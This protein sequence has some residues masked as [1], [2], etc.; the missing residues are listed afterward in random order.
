MEPIYDAERYL[1]YLHA[2]SARQ[3]VP[4]SGTFELTARCNLDC[5]MCYIHRRA[6]DREAVAREKDT[7]FWLALAESARDAGML[8]LLL[9]GG[10]PMLRPDFAILLRTLTDMGLLVSINTNGTLLTPELLTVMRECPPQRVNVTLYGA[11]E[12]T[13]RAL[14]G[15]G[16]VYPRVLRTIE[17]MRDAGVQVKINYSVTP[18]NR[19]DLGAAYGL[20]R[21]WKLPMQA[22][23]YMFPPIRAR[24]NGEYEASRL[25]PEEAAA[26]RLRFDRIRYSPKVYAERRERMLSGDPYPEDGDCPD[27]PQERIRC[28]AGSSCFWVTWDGCMRPCG[29]MTT[30]SVRLT[31]GRFETF[32]GAW[33]TLRREREKIL[34]PAKCSAC[35][36]RFACGVCPAACLAETGRY[37]AVP[38]YLCRMTGEYLKL[39]HEDRE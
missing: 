32:D 11:S 1:Q 10:E 22:V 31:D 34:V 33:Q 4:L 27:Q 17:L 21:E 2:L 16:E 39:L 3:G 24:E 14:C 23:P 13:Y 9:T 8:S 25:S 15:S 6:Q 5:R 26:E 12:E 30:P 38:E 37:E 18:Y 29:M 28:R 20:C 19:R 7:A 36:A 35:K